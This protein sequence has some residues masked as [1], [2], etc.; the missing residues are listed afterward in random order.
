MDNIWDRYPS[1]SEGCC[2]G[3][4][5]KRPCRTKKSRTL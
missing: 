3:D 2:G 4:K 1:R 5:K